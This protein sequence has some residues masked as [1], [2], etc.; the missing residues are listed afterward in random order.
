MAKLHNVRIVAILIV[1]CVILPKVVAATQSAPARTALIN[2]RKSTGKKLARRRAAVTR[3][4][5]HA[6]VKVVFEPL[7]ISIPEYL[8]KL[9]GIRVENGLLELGTLDHSWLANLKLNELRALLQVLAQEEAKIKC[10][11]KSGRTHRVKAKKCLAAK[12]CFNRSNV[13]AALALN[14]ASPAYQE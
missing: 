14:L 7:K 11:D 6:P 9:P 12:Q 5:A 13:A 8:Q 1:V 4:L 10:F 2:H 3:K